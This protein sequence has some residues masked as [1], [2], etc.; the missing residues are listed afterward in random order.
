MFINDQAKKLNRD[1][2][3]N[4]I[5]CIDCR[6][7]N[8]TFTDMCGIIDIFNVLR[9]KIVSVCHDVTDSEAADAL[10]GAAEERVR[11]QQAA[12]EDRARG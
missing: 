8:L 2:S 1:L 5:S 10:F 7:T 11:A 12:A 4:Y 3:E 6:K 9:C